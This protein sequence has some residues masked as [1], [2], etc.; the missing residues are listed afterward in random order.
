MGIQNT[1]GKAF[2]FACLSSLYNHLSSNQSVVVEQNDA[3]NTA[4]KYY[5]NVSLPMKKKL[6]AGADAATR[7]ILRLEPQLE[8]SLNN[9]PL[10]L[11]IQTDAKGIAGDVRDV[12]CY[13][14]QNNWEIGISCKHNHS[15]VKHSRLSP[16]IDFGQ[17]WLNIPCSNN[18]F[19]RIIPLFDDLK[20]MRMKGVLWRTLS[21]KHKAYYIPLLA[22]F[23]E[24]LTKIYS[25]YPVETPKRLLQY[26][27]GRNDFYKVI[28]ND[29]KCVTKIQCFNIYGNLNRH[30]GTFRS[31]VNV[32]TLIMPT[33]IY[34]IN[35]KPN[36]VTTILVACD[37]GWTIS[38][39]MHNAESLVIP[40]LKFD[41]TLTGVPDSLHS[42][43]EPW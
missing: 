28:T 24:E 35:F 42:Q 32:P 39:R 4:Q 22:A 15:A 14:E 36:S 43:F 19:D 38:M 40:S 37:N 2:E 31:L 25:E 16:R 30:S 9:S 13:R 20:L 8:N 33:R 12:I 10:H 29:R 18:Y 23:M 6:D 7:I 11:A 1:A 41:V 21:N 17:D 5:D 3:L 26:L 34:D 27:L